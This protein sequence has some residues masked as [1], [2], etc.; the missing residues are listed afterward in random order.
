M[1]TGTPRSISTQSTPH[2]IEAFIAA[3]LAVNPGNLVQFNHPGSHH[4]QL[5]GDGDPTTVESL[6]D[7]Q[8]AIRD[9]FFLNPPTTVYASF[10]FC[11]PTNP[12]SCG[13]CLF[14]HVDA[15][16]E[17]MG[18]PKAHAFA[19]YL[20]AVEREMEFQAPHLRLPLDVG[21]IYFGGGTPNLLN[22]EE[23]YGFVRTILGRFPPVEGVEVTF[24]GI[25]YLYKDRE[26]MEALKEAGVNRVSIGAQVLKEEL[27]RLSGRST[28]TKKGVELAIQHARD[29]GLDHSVDLIYGWPTQTLEDLF[30]D[31]AQ[32][33][34]WGVLHMTVYPL[35]QVKEATAFSREPLLSQCASILERLE[36]Y[37][38]VRDFLLANGYRQVTMSDFE[39]DDGRSH[40]TYENT[41]HDAL[42]DWWAVGYS[43]VHRRA[44]T[45]DHPGFSYLSP[46][47]LK[48]YY[49]QLDQ[50]RLPLRAYFRFT[51]CD[52]KLAYVL[53]QLQ[54]MR[55]RIHEYQE[56]FG[57]DVREEYRNLWEALAK[58]GWVKTT[59]REIRLVGDAVFYTA[60]IQ[61]MITHERDGELRE[62]RSVVGYKAADRLASF[63]SAIQTGPE[64]VVF[65]ADGDLAPEA[66]KMPTHPVHVPLPH[67][68]PMALHGPRTQF[69]RVLRARMNR[70][71]I[72][73]LRIKI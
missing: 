41:T 47:D 43:G 63:H 23:A 67:V 32:L 21:A 4:F 20:R 8:N 3:N 70:F 10:P 65:F 11:I 13:F 69:L 29:L 31:V 5:V 49:A 45:W 54:E 7:E 55:I 18:E 52:V 14:P 44:G 46:H 42:S 72:H 24:E 68:S 66:P 37:R 40:Y 28:Q 50:G 33:V 64:Q 73:P 22:G 19:R 34:V 39:R 2:E 16:L 1:S 9:R 6:L 51:D 58:R 26:K 25:P 38:R 53:N 30:N 48:T 61:R 15:S 56:L 59:D 71:A 17:A 57:M 36:M 60:F 27:I 62:K 12:G 35:N